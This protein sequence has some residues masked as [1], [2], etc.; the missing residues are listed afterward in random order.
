M[1]KLRDMEE[2]IEEIIDV[3]MKSYMREAL[4][5]YMTDAY[6]ACIVLSFIAIFEDIYAKL[7][8]LAKTNTTARDIYNQIKKQRD[9]QKVF[10]S[11][12]LTRLKSAQ[13][14]SELD[15]D[16]LDVLRKLRNKAAH[17][18]G[19][20]P[21]AEEARYVFAETI[22]RFLA[23]PVLSTTQVADQIIDKLT[24]AYLFPTIYITDHAKIV[25]LD[26]KDLHED[27]YNYLINKL[28]AS[29]SDPNQ[30]VKTNSRRYILGLAFNP[31]NDKVLEQIKKQ[32]IETGSSDESRRELLI[33]CISAN[34][35]LLLD[36]EAMVYVRLNAMLEKTIKTTTTA[37]QPNHLTHPISFFK[38]LVKVGEQIALEYFEENFTSIIDKYKLDEHVHKAVKNHPWAKN[39]VVCS[40]MSDAGSD[41]FTTA[42]K[43]ADSAYTHDLSLSTFLDELE[44]FE[45]LL[46]IYDAAEEGAFSAI[47]LRNSKFTQLKSV[48]EKALSKT[49]DLANE[50]EIKL[51][52]KRPEFETLSEFVTIIS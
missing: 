51:K 34:S 3:N 4:T 43:F 12:L 45:L 13:I 22:E 9:E 11:D 14:I 2:L 39:L 52:E 26:V 49:T 29:F 42:N 23:K 18:S 7:N 5:C 41:Q 6:R 20:K 35:N 30:Q 1:A 50:Y 10:E 47:R 31:L 24:H 37:D 46:N 33:S 19:H 16:F 15:A 28:L 27:G 36:L 44:C 25:N 32:I 40:I 38:S 8:G 48:K 17:P 21:K